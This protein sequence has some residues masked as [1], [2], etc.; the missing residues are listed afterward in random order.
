MKASAFDMGRRRIMIS[1]NRFGLLLPMALLSGCFAPDAPAPENA[2]TLPPAV[3]NPAPA[4]TVPVGK[5][6]IGS[7]KKPAVRPVA[8][9]A[10]KPPA[11]PERPA[12]PVRPPEL[13]KPRPTPTV[14][15]PHGGPHSKD[16]YRWMWRAF[17][18]LTPQEQ[19]QLMRIQRQ[20][21]EKFRSIMREKTNRLFAQQEARR[22][23][24]DELARRCRECREPARKQQLKSELREKLRSDF[25][26]R[27]RDSRR[28]LETNRERLARMEVELT[29]R[30]KNRDTIVEALLNQR[31]NGQTQPPPP[32]RRK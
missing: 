25:N 28:D 24:L 16:Q 3:E 10:V 12:V 21:P 23:E 8:A 14:P 7:A 17:S 11:K 2:P 13:R 1:F 9:P 20:D 18:R 6:P 26:Q 15:P 22:K 31:L 4:P 19:Q 29:R 5:T 32:P 27:L 30:E